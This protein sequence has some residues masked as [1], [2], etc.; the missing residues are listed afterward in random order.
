[1]KKKNKKLHFEVLKWLSPYVLCNCSIKGFEFTFGVSLFFWV[2]LQCCVVLSSCSFCFIICSIIPLCYCCCDFLS[3]FILL[4]L[5]QPL[6]F[7]VAII[8][9]TLCVIIVTPSFCVAI[10][11]P[12]LHTSHYFCCDL[13]TVF[14]FHTIVVVPS[15]HPSHCHFCLSCTCS[16]TMLMCL[17]FALRVVN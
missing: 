10:V 14:T 13:H 11:V 2:S 3:C 5:C 6:M 16:F 12:S 1:L 17:S 9:K 4:L 7:H 15:F 8:V